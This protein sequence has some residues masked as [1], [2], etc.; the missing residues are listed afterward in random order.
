[1]MR[2]ATCAVRA[3]MA[4][5]LVS[6]GSSN[7]EQPIADGGD[8][9]GDGAVGDETSPSGETFPDFG[10]DSI[11]A[12]SCDAVETYLPARVKNAKPTTEIYVSPTRA[13]RPHRS[14]AKPLQA[15]HAAT[16]N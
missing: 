11:A 16:P 10:T 15:T 12:P 2:Q 3:A 5:L 13:A 8:D 1:M 9:G 4:A 7:D 6:C 14:K